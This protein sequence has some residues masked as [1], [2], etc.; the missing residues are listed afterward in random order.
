MMRIRKPEIAIISLTLAFIFFI[1]GFFTRRSFSNISLEGL[2][3]IQ[4]EVINTSTTGNELITGGN[5]NQS[6]TSLPDSSEYNPN[7][8]AAQPGAPLGGDGKININTA[9]RNE[10]MDL[11]GIGPALADSII[12]YRNLNG[13]FNAIE[14]IMNVSG[15]AEGRFERIKDRIKV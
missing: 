7:Q 2:T 9:T 3:S 14:D 4:P 11:V 10:L 5:N 13:H 15:I 1:A 6:A 8:L 12:E